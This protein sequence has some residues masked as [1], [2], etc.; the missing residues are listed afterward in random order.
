MNC[1]ASEPIF[2]ILLSKV[3]VRDAVLLFYGINTIELSEKIKYYLVKFKDLAEQNETVEMYREI[4]P[5]NELRTVW[6]IIKKYATN[7]VYMHRN[8]VGALGRIANLGFHN[9]SIYNAHG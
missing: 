3:S 1:L 8:K 9:V 5:F 2:S 7:V 6:K 4:N